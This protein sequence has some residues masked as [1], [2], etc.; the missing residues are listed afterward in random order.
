MTRIYVVMEKCNGNA[1]N[2]YQ[3]IYR[4]KVQNDVNKYQQ[5]NTLSENF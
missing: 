1:K 3:K 4:T 2:K 5:N